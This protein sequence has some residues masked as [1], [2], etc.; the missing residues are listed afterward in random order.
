M[1]VL[2]AQLQAYVRLGACEE[3]GSE[4]TAKKDS[5]LQVH[6]QGDIET[7]VA[8]PLIS[9]YL[10]VSSFPYHL[11]PTAKLSSQ[12]TKA[13]PHRGRKSLVQSPPKQ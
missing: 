2:K 5:A 12:V 3:V 13:K 6:L 10:E 7:L 9:G 11:L 8:P 4:I 1:C